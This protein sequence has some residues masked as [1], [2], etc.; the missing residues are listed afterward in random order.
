ML[1]YILFEPDLETIELKHARIEYKT[2]EMHTSA[3]KN[4]GFL[5]QIYLLPDSAT[6]ISNYALGVLRDLL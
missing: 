3:G 2:T 5:K 6:I 4:T 1:T